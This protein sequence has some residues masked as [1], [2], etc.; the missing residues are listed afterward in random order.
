MRT[1]NG[2]NKETKINHQGIMNRNNMVNDAYELNLKLDRN[3]NVENADGWNE[4]NP[5]KF[6]VVLT[7]DGKKIPFLYHSEPKK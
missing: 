5:F 1:F 6:D 4:K 7:L 3:L 2:E